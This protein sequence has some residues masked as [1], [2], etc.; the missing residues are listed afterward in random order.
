VGR[1]VGQ[2]GQKGVMA[3]ADAAARVRGSAPQMGGREDLFLAGP[4]QE[5]KQG[6]RE[7][8]CE[9]GGVRLRGHD[10]AAGE[11][12]GPRLRIYQTVSEG[13]FSEVCIHDPTFPR[14]YRARIALWRCT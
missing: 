2:G 12:V 14:S 9:R 1:G 11:K 7:T 13:L 8:V 4:E 5:T 6:L 3:K 10:S